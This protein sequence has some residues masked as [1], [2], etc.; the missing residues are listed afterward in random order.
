[1]LLRRKAEGRS[2]A[3]AKLA[4][5]PWVRLTGSGLEL[6]MTTVL[7]GAI[8]LALDRWAQTARPVFAAIAGLIG[9]SLGMFRFIRNAMSVSAEQRDADS[10]GIAQAMRDKNEKHED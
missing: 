9:F 2:P 8:G 5:A 10:E 6:A 3:P 7:F 1:M 4:A